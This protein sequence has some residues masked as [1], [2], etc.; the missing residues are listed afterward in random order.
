[1]GERGNIEQ[2]EAGEGCRLLTRQG[3]EPEKEPATVAPAPQRGVP[4]EAMANIVR[5]IHKAREDLSL[6]N[7]CAR[8]DA[9]PALVLD[10]PVPHASIRLLLGDVTA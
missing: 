6:W 10:K 8:V 2:R 4:A 5:V 7:A 3:S 9:A 1:M